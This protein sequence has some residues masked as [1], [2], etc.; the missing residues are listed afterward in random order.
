MPSEYVC[1]LPGCQVSGDTELFAAIVGFK[2]RPAIECACHETDAPFGA[3][4]AQLLCLLSRG[5]Q[6]RCQ[7]RPELEEDGNTVSRRSAA[8]P[9]HL[10][11]TLTRCR[12]AGSDRSLSAL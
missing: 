8:S 9:F 7:R 12:A 6:V 3:A 11:Q 2:R 1:D 4:C 5:E 10:K